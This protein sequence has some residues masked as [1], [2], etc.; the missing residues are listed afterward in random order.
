MKNTLRKP[1]W[2]DLADIIKNSTRIH[3][4]CLL[5]LGLQALP[6]SAGARQFL[7]TRISNVTTNLPV[8]RRLS[9][10]AVLFF[11]MRPPGLQLFDCAHSEP[12]PAAGP[13]VPPR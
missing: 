6:W 1:A 2:T 4:V 11:F 5:L 12:A 7:P 9:I 13:G 3:F 10:G 8:L